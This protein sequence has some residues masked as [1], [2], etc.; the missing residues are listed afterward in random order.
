MDTDVKKEAGP[1]G[2]APTASTTAALVMGD[3]LAIALLE[4]KGFTENDF[5][6]FHPGG[7]LGKRLLLRVDDMMHRGDAMPTVTPD[8]LL[9]NALSVI[10]KISLKLIHRL[11]MPRFL[12][13][14]KL[15]ALTLFIVLSKSLITV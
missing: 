13:H 3:A 4:A 7:A 15:P 1:I 12:F 14:L 11:L 2:L 10:I 8:T 6:R 9:T 5:A